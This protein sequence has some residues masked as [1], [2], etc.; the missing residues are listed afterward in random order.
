MNNKRIGIGLM[1]IGIAIIVVACGGGG[2]SKPAG[3]AGVASES[4]MINGIVVPPMPD[5]TTNNATLAGVD[6]NGNGVRDDVER[7]LAAQAKNQKDFDSAVI[8]AR[9]YQGLITNPTPATRDEA[10]KEFSNITCSL[11]G[12]SADVLNLNITDLIETT[13]A[14]TLAFHNFYD[15]LGAYGSGELT[16]CST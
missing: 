10:L 3:T 13:D 16:P 7:K 12:A 15:V 5:E 14:R 6:S 2:P 8:Y 1:A 4:E 9:E 11:N